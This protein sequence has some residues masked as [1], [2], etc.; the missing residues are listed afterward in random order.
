MCITRVPFSPLREVN[1]V[2][3]FVSTKHPK[4]SKFWS[5]HFILLHLILKFLQCDYN[6]AMPFS[7][8]SIC[9]MYFHSFRLNIIKFHYYRERETCIHFN[10]ILFI[11]LMYTNIYFKDFLIKSSYFNFCYIY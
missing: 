10:I 8:I 7:E 3:L 1:V 11:F 5:L 9:Y 2:L 6:I 4:I